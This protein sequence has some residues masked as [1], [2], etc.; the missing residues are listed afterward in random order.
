MKKTAKAQ[1]PTPFCTIPEAARRS[2]LSE[3]FVR[4]LCRN[5][6]IPCVKVGVKYLIPFD[7]MVEAVNG[8]ARGAA[9]GK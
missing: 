3:F 4:K 1:E 2:G 7:A 9:M 6:E 8:R 5:G